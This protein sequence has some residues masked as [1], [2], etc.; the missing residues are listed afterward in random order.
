MDGFAGVEADDSVYGP[1]GGGRFA[2]L[3]K[4]VFFGEEVDHELVTG[5]SGL[6]GEVA[7]VGGVVSEGS[8]DVHPDADD[9]GFAASHGLG[10]SVGLVA[11]FFGGL[12]DF[13]PGGLG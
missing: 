1:D 10:V 11:N 2:G 7:K 6:G 3:S 4:G 5:C 8:V 12:A 13:G 9:I